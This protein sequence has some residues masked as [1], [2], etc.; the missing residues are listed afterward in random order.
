[1]ALYN[2]GYLTGRSLDNLEWCNSDLMSG[3]SLHPVSIACQTAS[4][5]INS[6]LFFLL[7]LEIE[8]DAVRNKR[9]KSLKQKEKGLPLLFAQRSFTQNSHSKVI[10]CNANERIYSM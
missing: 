8:M 1:M 10:S 4:T 9:E 5:K 6:D 7:L 3:P 2:H